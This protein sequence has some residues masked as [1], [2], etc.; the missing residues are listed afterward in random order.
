MQNWVLLIFAEIRRQI[1]EGERISLCDNDGPLNCIF[2]LA[3]VT[4]P[5]VIPQ[6]IHGAGIDVDH[7]PFM[8]I[9][10]A[11]QEV[12]GNLRDVFSV[13]L[14]RRHFN[15]HHIDAVIQVLAELAFGDHLVEVAMRGEDDARPQRN[16]L[17]CC[18]GG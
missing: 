11:P 9:R 7:G 1:L 4:G 2:E 10:I 18:P 5:G 15:A 12:R 13:V 8:E 16:Q 6:R 17:C 14:K 3:H